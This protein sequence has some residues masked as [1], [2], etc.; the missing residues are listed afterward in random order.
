MAESGRIDVVSVREGDSVVKNE[1][2]ARQDDAVLQASLVVANQRASANGEA[3]SARARLNHAARRRDDIAKLLQ[4]SHASQTELDQADLALRE[5]EAALLS[6][7]ER[8]DIARAEVAKIE[9]ELR[10]REIRSPI[11]GVVIELNRRQGEFA[12]AADYVIAKVAV[13]EQLRIRINVP[14]TIAMGMSV[15]EPIEIEF[16]EVGSKTKGEIDFVSPVTDSQSGTVRVDVRVDNRSGQLRSGLLGV[17]K[18]P[19]SDAEAPAPET[20]PQAA[21]NYRIFQQPDRAFR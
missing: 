19:L 4:E 20:V 1:L 6:V 18:R 14:T 9:A 2:I 5:A 16:P 21:Q 11:D 12:G 8:R 7:Q 10:R 13:L 17:W 15:G 3:E